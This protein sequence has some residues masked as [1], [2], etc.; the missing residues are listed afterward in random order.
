MSTTA[1]IPASLAD[2]AVP[3]DELAPYHPNPCTGDLDS[4]AEPLCTN[5]QY[6]PIV[7]NVARSPGV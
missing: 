1:R 2:L 6:R 4:I 3:V 7:V 5:G